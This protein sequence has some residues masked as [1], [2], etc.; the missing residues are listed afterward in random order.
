MAYYWDH[1]DEIQRGI[2]SAE[3][4]VAELKARVGPGPLAEQLGRDS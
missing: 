3:N 1:R 4:R 2:I